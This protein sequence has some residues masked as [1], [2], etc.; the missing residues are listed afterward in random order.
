MSFPF[1]HCVFLCLSPP[2][3]DKEIFQVFFSPWLSLLGHKD[4]CFRSGKSFPLPSKHSQL[5][6]DI[7]WCLIN[8]ANIHNSRTYISIKRLSRPHGISHSASRCPLAVSYFTENHQLSSQN[9]RII[10][11]EG[12]VKFS[13]Q[14]STLFHPL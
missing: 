14:T 13:V 10:E 11:L 3:L 5:S 1:S 2:F 7:E 8:I 4:G 6:R 12:A 9:H